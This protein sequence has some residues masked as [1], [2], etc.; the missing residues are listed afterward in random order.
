MGIRFALSALSLLYPPMIV[1]LFRGLP[2]VVILAVVLAIGG[3]VVTA[4]NIARLVILRV[5]MI[6]IGDKSMTF[7]GVTIPWTLVKGLSYTNG[8]DGRG[9]KVVLD[10]SANV[11]FEE[12]LIGNPTSLWMIRRFVS[13]YHG[14]PI[15]QARGIDLTDLYDSIERHR[16]A[17]SNGGP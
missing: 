12:T 3:V 5:P 14:L 13:R 9:L 10:E 6:V 8:I 16:R 2:G 7:R 1:L 11:Y 17:S 15:P 4:I